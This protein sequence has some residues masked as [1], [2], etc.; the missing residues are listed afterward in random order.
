MCEGAEI[1]IRE[2][3]GVTRACMGLGGQLCRDGEKMG[4]WTLY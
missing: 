1:G 3:R 4:I 2:Y